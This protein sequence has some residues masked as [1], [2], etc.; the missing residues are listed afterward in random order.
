MKNFKTDYYLLVALLISSITIAQPSIKESSETAYISDRTVNLMD[1]PND[2][3]GSPYYEKDFLKGSIV[4]DGK[5]IAINQDLRYNV[6][7]EEFEIKN[8]NK[9]ESKIVQTILRNKDFEIKIGNTSFEY[10]SSSE[11][12]LRGYFIPLFKGDKNFLF[13]KITKTY[14]PAQKAANSM[15]NDIAAMYREKEVMFLVNDKGVF[16]ELAGSKGRKLKAFGNLKNE[17]KAY[18]KENKLNLNKEK[19]LIKVVSYIDSLE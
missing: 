16:T 5:I 7:K 12:N 17:V 4:K 15:S 3:T 1:N 2:Y 13:K 10:I 11:N 18:I 6:S 8:P 14:L 19:D 9:K